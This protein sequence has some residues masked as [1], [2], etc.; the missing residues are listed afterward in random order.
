MGTCSQG[1]VHC[2][3]LSVCLFVCLSVCLFVCLSVCLFVCLSACLRSCGCF[4]LLLPCLFLH[5]T[6][7]HTHNVLSGGGKQRG[8]TGQ[9]Q[10]T[11][12]VSRDILPGARFRN[13]GGKEEWWRERKACA[14]RVKCC[15]HKAI[16]KSKPLA[17][18]CLCFAPAPPPPPLLVLL[19]LTPT[20]A[21]EQEHL[22]CTLLMELPI[23]SSITRSPM[24]GAWE[25][26]NEPAHQHPL[27]WS[28][29]RRE[30]VCACV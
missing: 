24:L 17:A 12:R 3:C 21:H 11:P 6:H 15:P 10:A 18:T 1:C 16:T 4:S 8:A 20:R 23:P 14:H 13:R 19:H 9:P 5:C 28:G 27:D 2:R 25:H 29:R 26:T 22:Q 30:G 7:T